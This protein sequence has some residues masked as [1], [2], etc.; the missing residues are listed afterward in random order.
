MANFT[1]EELAAMRAKEQSNRERALA[2]SAKH[3]ADVI[4]SMKQ[5]IGMGSPAPQAAPQPMPQQAPAQPGM[6]KGGKVMEHKHHMEH[7]KKHA[8][9]HKHEQEKAAKHSAGHKMHHEHVKKM[10]YGGKTK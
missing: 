10:C 6:K 7:V 8:A 9:G 5:S 4:N 3:D 2:A 1:K